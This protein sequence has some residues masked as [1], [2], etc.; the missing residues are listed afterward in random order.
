MLHFYYWPLASITVRPVGRER[1]YKK[2]SF[3][4]LFVWLFDCF[5]EIT[6]VSPPCLHAGLFL[7]VHK[8][9]IS[10][11]Q[12]LQ[13]C[14]PFPAENNRNIFFSLSEKNNRKWPIPEKLGK[15]IIIF[16]VFISKSTWAE[17]VTI[18]RK[19]RALVHKHISPLKK[20]L[21]LDNLI[22]W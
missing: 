12:T 3:S 19:E 16:S 6:V 7:R 20:A 15:K 1:E 4:F 18:K 8:W 5:L 17:T 22:F 11:P 14:H 13:A 2:V 10:P 21:A 9:S